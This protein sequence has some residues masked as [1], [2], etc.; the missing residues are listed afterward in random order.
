MICFPER[1]IFFAANGSGIGVV[2]RT[3]YLFGGSWFGN[4]GGFPNGV[5]FLR[6]FV[7][8]LG[9]FPERSISLGAV[10]S[11]IGVVSRTD[12]LFCGKRF[13]FRGVFPNGVS[14]LRQTVR[15]LGWF[16]ERNVHSKA[17]G[18]GIGVFPRTYPIRVRI[19]II[20]T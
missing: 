6:Q 3:D 18:S 15:E 4:W 14:L 11:G 2:S 9:W 19:S 8:V 20:V 10:G 1:S 5:S 16:P 12:Y 7:W 13:G 17:V